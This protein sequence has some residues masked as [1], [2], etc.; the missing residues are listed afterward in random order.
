MIVVLG[1]IAIAVC[2]ALM[3]WNR[4]QNRKKLEV[5][6]LMRGLEHAKAEAYQIATERRELASELEANKKVVDELKKRVAS[7]GCTIPVHRGDVKKG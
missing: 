2:S 1:I 3:F 6:E 4:W 7:V 5:S